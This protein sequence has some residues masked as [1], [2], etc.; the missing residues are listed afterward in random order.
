SA[1]IGACYN[2]D[3]S[4]S[5]AYNPNDPNDHCPYGPPGGPK[6]TENALTCPEVPKVDPADCQGV[7]FTE[8]YA[9]LQAPVDTGGGNCSGGETGG[10][11]SNP[12]KGI[13]PLK[14]EQEMLDAL[15]VY[16]GEV[17]RKY[18]DP[19]E[20]TKSWWVCN[21]RGDAGKLMPTSGRMNAANIAAVEKWLGCG[22]PLTPAA[23]VVGA[24]GAGGAG[25]DG[26]GG[27]G[28]QG[29][30]GGGP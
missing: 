5:E 1:G 8:V 23:K 24:G 15:S 30:A 3:Q 13:A 28:G 11:H 16:K 19:E 7:S 9:V 17:G 29:G 2:G 20:P 6:L 4:C 10:C 18:F 27:G 14:G 22:A 25:G 26:S 21:L 12:I